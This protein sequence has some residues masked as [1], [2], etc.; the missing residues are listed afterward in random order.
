MFNTSDYQR[1]QQYIENTFLM[2][3]NYYCS[4]YHLEI[5]CVMHKL[6]ILC[7][8]SQQNHTW[9]E[10]YHWLTSCIMIKALTSPN[11]RM[12]SA[13]QILAPKHAL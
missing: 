4:F 5:W 12:S 13:V 7:F 3:D 2:C 6:H 1:V 9:L 8:P 11:S 10:L